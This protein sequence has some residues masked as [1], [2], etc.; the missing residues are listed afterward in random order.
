VKLI[1]EDVI[2][3]QGYEV[4]YPPGNPVNFI[5]FQAKGPDGLKPD[6]VDRLKMQVECSVLWGV[7]SYVL[8]EPDFE[9]FLRGV[10]AGPVRVIKEYETVLETWAEAQIRTYNHVYYYPYHIEYQLWT[11]GAINWGPSIHASDL[12][13]ALD[14]AESGR[15]MKFFSEKNLRGELVDGQPS[16]SE[17]KMDY[18][19]TQWAAVSGVA[20]TI[21]LHLG[22]DPT[23]ELYK[24]LYY[25][26]NDMKGDPVE[27]DPGM[28]GKFGFIVRD[29]QKMGFGKW[30]VRFSVYA[31]GQEY[32]PG[33]EKDLLAMYERPYRGEVGRH[34]ALAMVPDAPA[35]TDTRQEPPRS[36]FA[37]QEETEQFT[38]IITPGFIWDPNLLGTGPG[39]GYSDIDFLRSGTTFGASAFW[40]DR[41][42]ATY[43]LSFSEL[44]FIEWVEAFK[45]NVGYSS[46]P[47]QPYYGQGN[48]SDKDHK[49][50][51]WWHKTEAYLKFSKNWGFVYGADFKIGYRKIGIDSG[52]EPR[53]GSGGLDSI[54]ERYGRDR[55]LVG[56][57]WGPP[58]YGL[59]GGNLHGFSLSFYRDMRSAKNLPK[60]GNSQSITFDVVTSALGADYDYCRT[61][62]DLRA[63]WHPD[64]LNPL[65]WPDDRINP[66]R[67]IL[68]KFFGPDKN[69][70]FAARL[71]V[72]KLFA[73]E[74]EYK[75]RDILDVPF[76]ELTALGSSSSVK[77]FS[78]SRFLDNDSMFG[79]LEYRWTWWKF[80]DTA[81][82][83]DA[84]MVMNDLFQPEDWDDELHYGY[85]LSLRI[86]VPP[87][88]SISFEWAWSEEEFAIIHQMNYAF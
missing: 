6:V 15:G 3:A 51:Y 70:A 27:S 50:L 41:G 68:Q 7:A 82:F 33:M 39:I 79:S 55:D 80:I 53:S 22:L 77:G 46:F 74:I 37:E 42:Y 9:H 30:P 76:Y 56:E 19:P 58:V 43:E 71:V 54:E 67:D 10:K 78:S 73:D 84:G 20:G 8:A 16:T 60:F 36:I 65:P 66:R 2:S 40:T 88:I 45:I 38:R 11:R 5:R 1:S 83:V 32:Q 17:V 21:M 81:L 87:N 23:T 14:L 44:R 63:Y 62:L 49:T 34:Q 28:L 18:G 72:I 64:F 69:R 31:A 75:G 35:V 57:R 48:D 26:D 4:E 85:G 86:H 52:I 59:E 13:L 25:V 29:Q 61:S 47:A 24:D 12:V